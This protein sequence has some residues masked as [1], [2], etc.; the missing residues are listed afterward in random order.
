MVSFVAEEGVDL[1]AVRAEFFSIFLQEANNRLFEG[2]ETRRIPVHDY[3]NINALQLLGRALGHAIIQ[4]GIGLPV[5]A[6]YLFSF[7][8]SGNAEAV[9][10]TL[11]DL[12]QCHGTRRLKSFLERV[13][14]THVPAS[15]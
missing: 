12:P 10:P 3:G 13:G 1:G 5:F 14:I 6:P 11:E 9:G 2:E 8:V 7:L 15:Y 4:Q